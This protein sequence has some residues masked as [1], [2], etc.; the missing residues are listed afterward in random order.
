MQKKP[1]LTPDAAVLRRSA[2]TRLRK[3]QGTRPSETGTGASAADSLRLLHE[4]QVHQVELE[5][6]NEELQ[7]SRTEAEAAL[8]KYSELYEF[9]PVGY[10]S[11]DEQ[12]R[13][14]EVNLTGAAL[15]GVER[16]MLIGR[17]LRRFMAPPSRPVFLAFLERV[18]ARDGKQICEAS[19]LKEDGTPFWACLH[20]TSAVA[21][22]GL[23]N[24]CR[25]AVSDITPLKQAEEAKRRLEALGA[26]NQELTRDIV[27]RQAVEDALK[28]TQQRQS[29]MLEQSLQMQAQLRHLSRQILTTQ[30]KERKLISCELHEEITQTLATI[31]VHLAAI[32]REAADNPKAL[33]KHVLQT[34]RLVEKSVSVVHQFA[35]R[36][37][38]TTLDDLGLLPALQALAKK[39]TEETGVR[40][41]LKAFPELAELSEAKR[42]VL[43]RVAQEALSNAARHAQASRVEVAFEKLPDTVRMRIKDDGKSFAVESMWRSKK[44][45]PLGLLGMRERV[46]MLGGTFT[47]ES[48]PD[49]GTSVLAQLPTRK[50]ASPRKRQ[51]DVR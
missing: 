4:L 1:R 51:R 44:R 24:G 14:T 28:V 49:Q 13:V 41:N 29:Q 19:L 36:L 8:E 20:G 50:D 32:I 33:K 40:V 2:E 30:E 37:R 27:R 26:A 38:P 5:M 45:K 43:Y 34:Q 46:E 42:T 11:L 7:L 25:V 22:G 15:L 21:P 12:G 23:R 16:S 6:Q 31:N 39:F 48:A 9:A 3:Q 17:P 47:V 18:L 10:V 35:R